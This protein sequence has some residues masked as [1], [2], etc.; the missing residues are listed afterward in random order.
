MLRT[1]QFCGF[2]LLEYGRSGRVL[3]E[4]LATV[5]FFY[6]FFR[7]QATPLAS[8]QFFTMS[9]LF[10]IALTLY[11]CSSVLNLGDRPQGYVIL[12]RRIG[13]TGYLLGFYLAVLVI[14]LGAYGLISVGCALYNRP[15]G[16]TL[17]QWVLGSLPLALNVALATSLLL[18]LSSLVLPAGW[19]LVVLGL[20]AL[21]FSSNLLNNTFAQP[22]AEPIRTV[23]AAPLLPAFAGFELA[24]S[25][26]YDTPLASVLLVA[27]LLM[28]LGLLFLAF[29]AFGRRELIF[30]K[31]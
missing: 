23:L 5:A 24:V 28:T 1:L 21:A 10:T 26:A 20:L 12:S 14:V 8:E 25:R 11:A 29:Y 30:S 17:T 16:L 31:L 6:I 18:L 13:R 15:A 19:R 3:V 2:T 4:L 9:S 7:R 22:L 27:Q